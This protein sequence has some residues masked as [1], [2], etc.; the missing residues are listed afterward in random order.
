VRYC[1]RAHRGS[2]SATVVF[3]PWIDWAF[4][5]VKNFKTDPLVRRVTLTRVS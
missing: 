4:E 2:N 5:Y 1:V 3:V